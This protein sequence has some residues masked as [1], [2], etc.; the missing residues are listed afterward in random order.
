M[1]ATVLSVN[2]ESHWFEDEES[3]LYLPGTDINISEMYPSDSYPGWYTVNFS[4]Q[5]TYEN[6]TS[7]YTGSC[8]A[9]QI[10]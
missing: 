4:F 2:K 9:M 1:K 10:I 7:I 3:V 8:V 6:H 5:L